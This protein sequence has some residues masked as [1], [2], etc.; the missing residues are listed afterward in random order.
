M[1]KHWSFSFCLSSYCRCDLGSPVLL[2]I[3]CECTHV[4]LIFALAG[5]IGQVF[6]R[7]NLS[8]NNPDIS[9]T[10]V[11]TPLSSKCSQ[12]MRNGWMHFFFF[13]CSNMSTVLVCPENIVPKGLIF[14]CMLIVK[15]VF[16]GWTADF[17]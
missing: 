13:L 7:N 5:S 8:R 11:S 2:F 6:R 3:W 9:L 12:W 14:A 1:V 4:D 16:L 15:Q 17:F 10:M